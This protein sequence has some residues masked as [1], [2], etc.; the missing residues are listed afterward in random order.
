MNQRGCHLLASL[1]IQAF[2]VSASLLPPQLR[3]HRDAYDLKAVLAQFLEC[4]KGEAFL[5]H[6]PDL[7]FVGLHCLLLFQQSPYGL[8]FNSRS[9]MD[10]IRVA[11]ALASC[12]APRPQKPPRPLV[13]K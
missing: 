9:K 2:L 6:D 11:L 3:A 13:W 12:G 1:C 4:L 5:R 7:A 10:L 8:A